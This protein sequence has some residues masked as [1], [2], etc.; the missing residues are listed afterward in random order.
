MSLR[1]TVWNENVHESK[2]PRIAQVYPKGIHGAIAEALEENGICARTATLDMPSHGLTKEVLDATDVLVWWGH[3]AHAKV[4][5]AVVSYAAD[6]VL[7][8]GMGLVVLHSGLGSKL[9]R[10]LVGTQKSEVVYRPCGS[11]ET[12]WAVDPTHPVTRGLG[13]TRLELPH[14]ESY[15]ELYD[16]R[17]PDAIP[18]LSWFGNADVFRSGYAYELGR[19]RVFYFGPGHEEYPIYY[20]PQVRAVLARAVRWAGREI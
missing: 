13:F 14:E 2:D 6:R 3:V 10:A 7:E 20:M 4:D 15:G 11:P 19:G 18:F 12:L 8:G 1:A 9:F 16:I 5:D 17:M